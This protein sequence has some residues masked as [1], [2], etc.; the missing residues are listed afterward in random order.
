MT[1]T[2]DQQIAEVERELALRSRV[3]PGLVAKKKMRQSEADE[4]TR[5]MQDVL[6]TLRSL[7]ATAE[8]STA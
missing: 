1:V 3:Y 4:H 6:A 5:R 2:L 7:R 8:K